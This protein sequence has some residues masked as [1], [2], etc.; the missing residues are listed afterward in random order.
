MS[1]SSNDITD[2]YFFIAFVTGFLCII[3]GIII[4]VYWPGVTGLLVILIGLVTE[5][6]AHLV[7]ITQQLSSIMGLAEKLIDISDKLSTNISYERND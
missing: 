1:N 3:G 4:L 2:M 6:V 7:F 5:V